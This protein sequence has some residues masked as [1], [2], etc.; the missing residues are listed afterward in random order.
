MQASSTLNDSVNPATS[1]SV[2]SGATSSASSTNLLSD[3]SYGMPAATSGAYVLGSPGSQ[4]T[5]AGVKATPLQ[6][7][8]YET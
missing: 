6:S 1:I 5:S 4:T 2:M 7:F 3:L 8:E